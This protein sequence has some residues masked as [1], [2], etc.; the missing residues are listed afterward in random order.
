M[1]QAVLPSASTPLRDD[2]FA[3]RLLHN[4]VQEQPPHAGG[5]PQQGW[6]RVVLHQT[7]Q[8]LPLQPLHAGGLAQQLR[9]RDVLH[10]PVAELALPS[11]HANG[12]QQIVG[13]EIL[14]LPVPNFHYHI[15][16]VV[17]FLSNIANTWSTLRPLH[18]WR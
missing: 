11:P 15:M 16:L 2:S 17:A 18:L 4:P 10:H 3:Q 6:G 12:A 5:L 13:Q 14:Y 7:V 1:G 9:G 8:N